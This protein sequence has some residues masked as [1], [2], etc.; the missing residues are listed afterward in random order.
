MDTPAAATPHPGVRRTDD[1]HLFDLA[2][3]ARIAH[4]T[5]GLDAFCRTTGSGVTSV[6]VGP[7]LDG[8][9][10]AMAG[11]GA[12]RNGRVLARAADLTVVTDDMAP[13]PDGSAAELGLTTET[14]VAAFLAQVV[15]DNPHPG[16]T[17]ATA[18]D[19]DGTPACVAEHTP[20]QTAAWV[21]LEHL[22]AIPETYRRT[23]ARWL[24][25]RGSAPASGLFA[26]AIQ[27]QNEAL[28]GAAVDLAYPLS[29]DST[30][31][32]AADVLADLT[33][34]TQP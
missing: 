8:Q 3:V 10:H 17:A 12:A 29:E 14:E 2:E 32:H 7:V 21:E 13:A 9:P 20:G 16:H 22:A 34:G 19:T 5:H 24:A 15:R 1:E 28:R 31:D 25:Q 11:P 30:N 27:T 33:R 18:D 6:W 4:E 26:Q 23:I